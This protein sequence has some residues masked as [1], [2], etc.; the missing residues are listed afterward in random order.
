MVVFWR[1]VDRRE[2]TAHERCGQVRIAAQQFEHAEAVTFGL[3]NSTM[4]DGAQLAD[5][6]VGRAENRARRFIQRSCAGLQGAGEEGV[7][8]LISSQVFDQCLR[9]VHLVAPGE[10]GGEGIFEPAHLALG[11]AASQTGQQMVWQQVLAED[12]KTLFHQNS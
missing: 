9:H 12:K 4:I 2:F 10:P 6:T 3:E 5:G 11:N 8:V 7:E 1:Q